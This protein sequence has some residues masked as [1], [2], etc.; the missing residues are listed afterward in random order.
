M[1]HWII[2]PVVLPAVLGALIVLAMRNDLLLQRVFGLA[3]TVALTGVAL[4]LFRA[5]SLNPPEVYLLGN[6]PAPFGIVLMLD[7]LAA[8]LVLLTMVLALFVQLY[9]IGT[10]WDAKGRH[11]HALF[12]F[13]LMGLSGAFLTGDLFNLFVFFEVLLIA[14]YGLMIHGGGK[15]RLRAGVQYVAFN[16]VG[17][18]L[19]LFALATIYS[20]TGTLN[21]ADLAVKVAVLP[22]GDTAL[23]RVGAML[24]LLVFAIKGALVPLQ[25][26]LPGTY[27]AAPG[28]V[29]ALFA[30]MTKVGAYAVIRVYTLIFPPTAPAIGPM[31][32]DV[33]LPAALVTL[34]IGAIGVMGAGTLARLVAF[35]A[36]AS[37]GT[38]FTAVALFT[39]QGTAAALYYLLHSTFATAILFLLADLVL[40]RRTTGTLR[41]A[42][43]PV[44]QSGLL[45]ALFFAGAIA[46]AGMPPLSGFI[47]KLLILQ[48]A[49]DHIATV[50]PV[51]LATS[52]LM[53][54]GFAAAGSTLFWKA[55]ASPRPL[56]PKPP[57]PA[58]LPFVAIFGLL[59]CLVGLTVFAGPVMRSLNATSA[60]LYMPAPYIAANTLPA[61]D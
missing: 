7:R 1:T 21:M 14:S 25:F 20:V 12:L 38:L 15:D 58:A 4:A 18:T 31:I 3:G 35:A 24:L 29:A 50:W 56:G 43:P 22:Q 26:W 30:V 39:P 8:L 42:L 13:Q 41:Q 10:G 11:F 17:S 9:A 34:V 28:P 51:I 16:L 5:A 33:L 19:F 36:I 48:A 44:A 61:Q 52:L 27:A 6:W 32:G 53:I 2:V 37:M 55:H 40:S 54:L 59:A 57:D 45:A 47:G 49:R 60:G 46:L 23:L